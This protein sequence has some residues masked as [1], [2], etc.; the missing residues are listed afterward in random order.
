MRAQVMK[1]PEVMMGDSRESQMT[2]KYHNATDHLR[3]GL[4]RGCK[5]SS[6][7]KTPQFSKGGVG[8]LLCVASAL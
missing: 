5:C 4:W 7:A 3:L 1:I 6:S 8:V 2:T